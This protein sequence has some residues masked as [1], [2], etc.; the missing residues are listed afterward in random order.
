MEIFRSLRS[1][2]NHFLRGGRA[3]GTSHFL[4]GRR[5]DGLRLGSSGLSYDEDGN[6]DLVE[7]DDDEEP[8]Y[9][10]GLRNSISH[11]LRGRR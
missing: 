4:R 10:R 3:P 9:H 2:V 11:F 6:I 1:V 5:G 7:E 8:F